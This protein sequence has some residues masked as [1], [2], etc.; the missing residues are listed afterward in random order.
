[1]NIPVNYHTEP[2]LGPPSLGAQLRRFRRHMGL[3]TIPVLAAAVVLVGSSAQADVWPY[4]TQETSGFT[5][6]LRGGG[7][8]GSTELGGKKAPHLGVFMR[9]SISKDFTAEFGGSYGRIAGDTYSSDMGLAD[10]RVLWAPYQHKYFEPY[11]YAGV[12][13]A[14]YD[15]DRVDA[16]RTNVTS[17]IGW[18]A[19]VPAGLGIYIPLFANAGID[20]SVGYT[21]STSDDLNSVRSGGKDAFWSTG[22]GIVIGDLHSAKAR[23]HVNSFTNV[24]PTVLPMAPLSDPA[25]YAEQSRLVASDAS[26]KTLRDSLAMPRPTSSEAVLATMEQMVY[27]RNGRAELDAPAQ[28]VLRD[29]LPAFQ[30]NPKMR[31]II[32]GFTSKSGTASFNMALGLKRA[33][34]A[35][36]FLVAQGID[37]VRIEIS[38]LGEGQL[39]VE[40]PGRAAST[41]NR[42][43]QFRLLVADPHLVPNKI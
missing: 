32:T 5:V 33:E 27:F 36:A 13:M 8:V 12:G 19:T 23:P 3:R 2:A 30:A 43:V 38:T 14:R 28:A 11:G 16:A 17:G 26:Y 37:P 22:F 1:M 31:I 29:K 42:R 24:S 6:G 35:K 39:Q 34:A 18:A 40:G 21:Q 4:D 7:L 20:L 10:L 15:L 9:R 41:A 25:T